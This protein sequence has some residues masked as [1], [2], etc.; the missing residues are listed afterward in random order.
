MGLSDAVASV[1][2][3]ILVLIEAER[4]CKRWEQEHEL[5]YWHVDLQDEPSRREAQDAA[6][7]HE[8]RFGA[9][10]EYLTPCI[11]ILQERQAA[12]W[13]RDVA[14]REDAQ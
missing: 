2:R 9:V 6:I 10:R 8:A 13:L 12:L 5:D 3:D 1:T 14:A 11:A 4:L 7:S